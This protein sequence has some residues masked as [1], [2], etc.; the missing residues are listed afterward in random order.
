MNS[1]TGL[2]VLPEGWEWAKLGDVCE[3]Y[4][5]SVKPSDPESR[6]LPFL[7][8]EHVES[9]TGRILL[10][11]DC[12]MT[13]QIKSSSF[14]FNADHVLYG[15]LNPHLNKVAVAEFEGRCTSEI[16]PLIPRGVARDFLVLLLRR[17]ESV[18]YATATKR[19]STLPRTDM[20]RF[21]AMP[22]PL[23]PVHEQWSIVR[24]IEERFQAVDR[25][26]R[27]ATKQ[28]ESI[29]EIAAAYLR[30][31]FPKQGERLPTGWDWVT[32][33]EVADV[34]PRRPSRL[35][36]DPDAPTTFIPMTA[37]DGESGRVPTAPERRFEEVRRGYTYFEERDVL[38]AK[39]TPCMQNGKHF[40][41]DGLNGGFGFGTTE[42]HVIRPKSG[43]L[44]EWIHFFVRQPSLLKSA[45][46]HFRGA[47]GQQRLPAE[48]IAELRLP[49]PPLSEQERIILQVGERLNIIDQAKQSARL[50]L[51]RLANISGSYL[52]GAFGGTI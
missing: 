32:L 2:S 25:A 5:K 17:R 30:V 27:A 36:R 34:N 45:T 18:E 33:G 7:G 22:I 49:L 42:L 44:S 37:I 41:A 23:P 24:A 13:D 1:G 47:V 46:H 35:D 21:M 28:L 26:R 38:F 9:Q 15:K 31:V 11:P 6:S 52:R 29:A 48:F 14:H 19:G 3:P 10:S 51:D 8:L 43:L 16:V 20:T 39:I 4:R 40:I 50:Q 12:L